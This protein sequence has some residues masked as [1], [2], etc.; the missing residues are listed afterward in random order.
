LL[1]GRD[2]GPVSADPD[3]RD[4]I[5][6]AIQ[7]HAP[8]GQDAILTGWALVAEWIDHEG[9]RWLSKAHSA[10]TSPWS[11]GGMHHEALYGRWPDPEDD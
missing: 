5:H 11:A 3:P 4:A 6:D 8:R 1:S 2:L 10:S 7:K 9:E